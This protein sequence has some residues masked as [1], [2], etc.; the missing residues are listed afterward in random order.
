MIE[1][2]SEGLHH[3][4]SPRPMLTRNVDIDKTALILQEI[5]G[6]PFLNSRYL[7]DS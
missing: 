6:R 4:P 5:I 1:R 7:I 2:Q 3:C